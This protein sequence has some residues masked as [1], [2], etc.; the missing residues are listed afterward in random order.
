MSFAEYETS[1][2]R[3]EPLLL[4]LFRYGE[5]TDCII[6]YNN[7]D[8]DVTVSVQDRDVVRPIL[9]KAVPI[10]NDEITATGKP[11]KSRLDIRT[12]DTSTLADLFRLYPP[13]NVVTVTIFQGHVADV[14]QQFLAAWA[15]KVIGFSTD[16]ANRA[17]FVCEP[18]SISMKRVGL[19]RRWQY[20]CPHV[21]YAQGSFKCNASKT[22]ATISRVLLS[23]SGG[24][25]TFETTWETAARKPKYQGGL[26][27]WVLTDG[28]R[29]IRTILRTGAADGTVVIGGSP[30]GLVA[31]MAVDLVLGCN[32]KAG[33]A[34]QPDGDCGPLHNNIQNFGGQPWIPDK[35]PVGLVNNYW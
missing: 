17:S 7:G 28:R 15:G 11:D 12:S 34:A 3:G 4:Y 24:T 13:S 22:V 10:D 19:R 21:L 29:E 25:L 33:I 8:R 26:A 30:T 20:G 16:E 1:A 2:D 31:G 32:H 18:I 9:F 27:E 6:A 23:V 5:P 35:N 14:S